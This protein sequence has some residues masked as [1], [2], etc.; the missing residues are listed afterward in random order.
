VRAQRG[1]AL[2]AC[3]GRAE[4][5]P[6][7]T[8]DGAATRARPQ[9]VG[10]SLGGRSPRAGRGAARAEQ[11]GGGEREPGRGGRATGSRAPALG[12]RWPACRA[13]RGRGGRRSMWPRASARVLI[14]ELAWRRSA[15]RTRIHGGPA[16]CAGRKKGGGSAGAA[17]PRPGAGAAG[18]IGWDQTGRRCRARRG[19]AGAAPAPYF[20]HL[21]K[22][23]EGRGG[24]RPGAAE[25]C[26]CGFGKGGSCRG[27]TC[28]R[29][30]RVAHLSQEVGGGARGARRP[31]RR[32]PAA[33]AGARAPRRPAPSAP[34]GW[35]ARGAA[36][37]GRAGGNGVGLARL[38]IG[39]D[40]AVRAAGERGLQTCGITVCVR[41]NRLRSF[42]RRAPPPQRFFPLVYGRRRGRRMRARRRLS[43]G[44]GA[45]R[46]PP[47]APAGGLVPGPP[48]EA[49]VAARRCWNPSGFDASGRA[50]AARR[51]AVA[52]STNLRAGP[53]S[54]RG[55]PAGARPWGGRGPA[56]PRAVRGAAGC[57]GLAGRRPGGLVAR[58]Y[59][60]RNCLQDRP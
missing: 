27:P 24:P 13:A 50:R 12:G 60:F 35:M 45:R 42:G 2:R 38:T 26:G 53:S 58:G 15:A 7:L 21:C 14:A 33:S 25:R 32:R 18:R 57:A 28:W 17:P 4:R 20:L 46:A 10:P 59:L 19:A 9:P 40:G 23:G 56:A 11:K 31:R 44:R 5:A 47:R 52:G 48:S 29:P 43:A 16:A 55:P 41:S 49:P 39:T 30:R 36:A 37:R 51:A 22:K 1:P 54:A 34:A 3:R 6:G 8:P